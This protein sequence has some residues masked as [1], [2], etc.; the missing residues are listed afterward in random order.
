MIDGYGRL[1]GYLNRDQPV[2]ER[3]PSYNERLLTK[4]EVTPYFIWPNLNP[5]RRVGALRAAVPQPGTATPE[6]MA[7]T[8]KQPL[9]DARAAVRAAV[10]RA[11]AYGAGPSRRG[12]CPPSFA[13]SAGV[14]RPIDG[15]SISRRATTG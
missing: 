13:S 6:G 7:A 11:S 14:R 15:L 5:Y 2:G 8:A 3:P 12:S 4:G 1:L 10:L 9:D